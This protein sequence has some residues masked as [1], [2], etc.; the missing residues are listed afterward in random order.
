MDGSLL[1]LA[2]KVTVNGE[3]PLEG[4]ALALGITVYLELIL[5]RISPKGL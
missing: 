1:H 5:V 4:E 2:S 3:G